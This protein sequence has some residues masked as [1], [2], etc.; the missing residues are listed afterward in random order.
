[1]AN[2]QET[3]T[4]A[5]FQE[6]VQAYLARTRDLNEPVVLTESGQPEFVLQTATHYAELLERLEELEFVAAVKTGIDEADA[7]L[8][9]PVHEAHTAM[10]SRLGLWR[11]HHARRT[12]RRG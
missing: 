4:V 2:A 3:S 10:K 5:D 8:A 12:A 9:I 1:M 11:P 6:N 7:G